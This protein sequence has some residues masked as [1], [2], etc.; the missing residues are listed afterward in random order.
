MLGVMDI[1]ALR[2]KVLVEGQSQRSVAREMGQARDTVRRQ[3]ATPTP[4]RQLRQRSSPLL[5]RVRPRLDRFE[6][7]S[8]SRALLPPD[9]FRRLQVAPDRFAGDRQLA[10]HLSPAAAFDQHLVPQHVHILHP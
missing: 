8:S 1:Y 3:L 4:E 5:H 9:R 10:R 7:R 6:H 2:R